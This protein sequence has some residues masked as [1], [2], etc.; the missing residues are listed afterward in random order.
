MGLRLK[1]NLVLL[2]VA[3]FGVALFALISGPFLDDLARE[4]VLTRSRIMM[5]SAAQI[6]D[7][8]SEEIAPLLNTRSDTKFHVQA[9][10]AYAATKNLSGLRTRFPE[11][12]YREA[13]L[14]PTNLENRATESE[15]DIINDFRANPKKKE[16]ITERQT[17]NGR[18]LYLSQ[19]IVVLKNCLNCHES[20]ERTPQPMLAEYGRQNGFGWKLNEI[21]GA[22]IVSVPMTVPLANAAKSLKLSLLLLGVVFII[23][24]IAINLM[25]ELLITRPIIRMSR[26]AGDVSMGKPNVEE[27]VKSGSDEVSELSVSINRLKRSVEEAIKLLNVALK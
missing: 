7:Y 18:F 12:S 13:A 20:P 3:V 15:V 19:P 10:S 22:Q 23:L 25:I 8:T 6:R 2:V 24:I 17:H 21:I 1:L 27:Y 16:M 5:E 26:I 9:V 11:Y 14:N 4:E